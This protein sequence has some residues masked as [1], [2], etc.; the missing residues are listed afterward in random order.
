MG[1]L[2]LISSSQPGDVLMSLSLRA[3]QALVTGPNPSFYGEGKC[4]FKY[5]QS[6]RAARFKGGEKTV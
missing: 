3:P 4:L 2:T 5:M 6:V 1:P